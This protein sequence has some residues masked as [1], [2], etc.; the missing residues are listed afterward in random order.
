MRK[1]D[2]MEKAVYLRSVK[3]GFLFYMFA[4]CCW[5]IYNMVHSIIGSPVTL[6]L[7]GGILVQGLTNMYMQHKMVKDDDEYKE[8]SALSR[9]LIYFF[10]ALALTA[11]ILFVGFWVVAGI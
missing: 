6:V 8:P 2:E 4:L 7:I 9:I 11:A 5:V 3:Y 1:M 10:I